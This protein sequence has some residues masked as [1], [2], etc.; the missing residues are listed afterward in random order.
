MSCCHDY[1]LANGGRA[2]VHGRACSQL[3]QVVFLLFQTLQRLLRH[4]RPARAVRVQ[5]HVL[6]AL[7]AVAAARVAVN[8]AVGRLDDQIGQRGQVVGRVGVG[9]VFYVV[10]ACSRGLFVHCRRGE[11]R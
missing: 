10:V 6:A 3:E 4:A 2:H 1:S 7:T 5:A 11:D 8:A 9:A